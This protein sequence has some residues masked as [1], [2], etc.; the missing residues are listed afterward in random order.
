[1]QTARSC[2]RYARSRRGST[3]RP[4]ASR[5]LDANHR[6]TA[7]LNAHP[8]AADTLSTPPARPHRFISCD[9][10][11]FSYPVSRYPTQ[12]VSSHR[13]SRLP[14]SCPFT[15]LSTRLV[16]V[17]V[18]PLNPLGSR[19]ISLFIVVVVPAALRSP[20]H[21]FAHIPHPHLIPRLVSLVPHPAPMPHFF[22]A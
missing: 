3:R 1:M 2:M 4:R 21:S 10:S 15:T 17:I 8:P 22:I 20:E 12:P 18:K 16:S 6:A 7:S 19:A 9:I 13:V 5:C 11:V 14:C